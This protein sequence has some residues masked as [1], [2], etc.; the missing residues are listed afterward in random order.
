MD[1]TIIAGDD[2]SERQAALAFDLL[3]L[4]LGFLEDPFPIYHRQRRWDPVH[5][6]PDG[7]IS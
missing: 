2:E 6:C 7:L 3:R 4:E 1:G 5:R